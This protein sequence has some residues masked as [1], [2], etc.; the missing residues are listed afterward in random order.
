MWVFG[1]SAVG[2]AIV[3]VQT[4]CPTPFP[5]PGAFSFKGVIPLLLLHGHRAVA[6]SVYY[7][8]VLLVNYI[9]EHS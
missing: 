3:T 8:Y 2:N 4:P 6:V 1:K 5:P 9:I 7:C